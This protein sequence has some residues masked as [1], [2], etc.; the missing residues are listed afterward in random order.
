M[1]TTARWAATSPTRSAGRP[2]IGA[3]GS[4]DADLD[5]ARTGFLNERLRLTSVIVERVVARGELPPT[6]DVHVGASPTAS[7]G[8]ASRSPT[9]D[10][11]AAFDDLAMAERS[12]V[13]RGLAC[14]SIGRVRPRRLHPDD[15]GSPDTRPARGDIAVA[16]LV[17]AF[18]LLA[19][20]TG[21][22]GARPRRGA[23]SARWELRRPS[24][25]GCLWR[26]APPDPWLRAAVVVSYAVAG[27]AVGLAPPLGPWVA[28][29]WIGTARDVDPA[30]GSASWWRS[31]GVQVWGAAALTGCL[32]VDAEAAHPGAGAWLPLLLV[33]ALV[34]TTTWTVR[35]DRT[36]VAA[37]R[38]R[39]PVA[40][41]RRATHRHVAD[42]HAASTR[43]RRGSR[44]ACALL[45]GA[46][47]ADRSRDV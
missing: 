36:R 47:A 42:G 33:T 23:C 16:A 7:P 29:W 17:S 15:D 13:A 27:L 39:G 43:P 3:A 24:A 18:S 30:G 22:R 9:P 37:V 26:G 45:A 1:D 34:A 14:A 19:P 40:V 31:P 38:E 6:V 21:G 12:G 5:Q 2:L 32:V 46:A 41:R 11:A 44:H 35:A 10:A 25:K 8:R 4:T 28:I 20:V